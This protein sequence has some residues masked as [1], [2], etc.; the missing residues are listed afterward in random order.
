MFPLLIAKFIFLL[1]MKC[2]YLQLIQQIWMEPQLYF[3]HYMKCWA[4]KNWSHL[5]T[6]LKEFI[7][8]WMGKTKMQTTHLLTHLLKNDVLG[9]SYEPIN[10][11][12]IWDTSVAKG[13]K[14]GHWRSFIPMEERRQVLKEDESWT[15]W[16]ESRGLDGGGK[17]KVL[18]AQPCPTLYDPWTIVHQAP[19]SMGF[20]RPG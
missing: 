19:L 3:G 10:A 13:N 2:A 6:A 17:L 4:H 9:A 7:H 20:S 8:S 12:S 1:L 14:H 18:V 11:E 16:R 15:Q 5:N